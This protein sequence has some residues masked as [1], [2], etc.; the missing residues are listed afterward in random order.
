M[1]SHD[2][3]RPTLRAAV[4]AELRA[5]LARAQISQGELADRVGIHRATVNR[6]MQGGRALEV[7]VLYEFADA[8]DFDPGELLDTAKRNYLQKVASRDAE[9]D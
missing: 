1:P 6:L 4:A 2:V 3:D 9:G 5:A 7:E 8:L